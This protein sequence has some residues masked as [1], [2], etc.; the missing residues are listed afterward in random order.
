[1]ALRIELWEQGSLVDGVEAWWDDV[2]GA[3]DI[4]P[5]DYP[6]LDSIS[7][8]GDFVVAFASLQDLAGECLR[9]AQAATGT[10]EGLLSK[11]ADLCARA[12]MTTDAELRFNGD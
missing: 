5:G 10:L 9:L 8:Y 4:A 3:L 6:I 11:I 7:P 2:E 12:S 1:M